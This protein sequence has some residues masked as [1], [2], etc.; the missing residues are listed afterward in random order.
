M[1][2]A[3]NAHFE[4]HLLLLTRFSRRHDA[5]PSIEEKASDGANSARRAG[6]YR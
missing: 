2:P 1:L 6:G 3:I 4:N 5:Q